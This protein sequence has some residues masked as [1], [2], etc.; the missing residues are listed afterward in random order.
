M[1]LFAEVQTNPCF[2]ELEYGVH[3]KMFISEYKF[4][5]DQNNSQGLVA[6]IMQN[7]DHKWIL[8]QV[9]VST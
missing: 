7:F 6:K 1:T 8:F 3:K 2:L 9:V 4:P 5:T